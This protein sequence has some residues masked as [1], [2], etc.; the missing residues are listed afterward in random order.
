MKKGEITMKKQT[1]SLIIYT[2]LKLTK[3]HK[4]VMHTI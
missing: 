2:T 3:L 1:V 4:N